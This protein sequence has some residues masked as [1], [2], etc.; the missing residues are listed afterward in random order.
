MV[1]ACTYST[2]IYTYKRA[3]IVLIIHMNVHTCTYTGMP[4]VNM[5]KAFAHETHSYFC[6]YYTFIFAY[7]LRH[8]RALN[9]VFFVYV[10]VYACA[11]HLHVFTS[12]L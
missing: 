1:I 11:M 6:R 12:I 2:F 3:L 5:V 7:I 4:I 9:Y 8:H 10:N